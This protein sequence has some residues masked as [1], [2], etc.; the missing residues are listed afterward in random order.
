MAAVAAYYVAEHAPDDERSSV[1]TSSVLEK[2]FK[3]AGFPLPKRI[4]MTL[5][6]AA[7]AGYFDSTSERG[8]Y[9]LNPVGH[10]LVAHGL[11]SGTDTNARKKTAAKKTAAK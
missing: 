5:P 7:Q 11:P 2:Y 4:D 1:V 8:S 6:N 9:K 10:N 3:Q